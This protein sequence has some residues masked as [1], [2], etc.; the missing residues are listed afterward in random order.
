MILVNET[1][2]PAALLSTVIDD[3]RIAASVLV[4][5]TYRVAPAGGPLEL[6][7]E[8][9]WLVSGA[10]QKTPYGVVEAETPFMKGGVDLFLFGAARAPGKVPV[11][12][13]QV[14]MSVGDF[15]RRANVHGERIWLRK[16]GKHLEASRP[17]V[18][19]EMPLTLAH[20]FGGKVTWDGLEVPFMEN[21][22][23]KGFC[24]EEADAEGRALPNLEE[25]GSPMNVWNAQPATC[26]F[27]FCPAANAARFRNGWELSDA[28]TELSAVRPA[29]LNTAFPPMI[30][31]QARPG[32]AV[33]IEGVD[34]DG[35]VTFSLP[36]P[37][38]AV[39][40]SFGATAVTRVPA[41]DQLGVLVDQR[42]V[43]VT[44]RFPFRYVV[45]P[46]EKRGIRLIARGAHAS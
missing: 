20:A 33:R 17:G 43:F 18:F 9:P 5:V 15:M 44:Y 30:A 26:G 11:S 46:R 21:P 4:R 27:G 37:P 29:S 41:I 12:Q 38:V 22:A 42:R 24:M 35:P 32:D 23:G 31:P 25:P 1:S 28:Q 3:E 45:R 13:M 8:Q 2:L 6:D 16:G 40:L 19:V 7:A 34:H 39:H 10:P 14:T 36:E